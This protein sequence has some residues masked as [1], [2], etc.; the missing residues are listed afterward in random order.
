MLQETPCAVMNAVCSLDWASNIHPPAQS[1]TK[2]FRLHLTY[3]NPKAHSF[4]GHSS[5]SCTQAFVT[6][7]PLAF[8]CSRAGQTERVEWGRREWDELSRAMD[9]V[10]RPSPPPASCS[11][12]PAPVLHCHVPSPLSAVKGKVMAVLGEPPA[13]THLHSQQSRDSSR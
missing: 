4:L 12:P 2:T 7:V 11:P 8:F 6:L 13:G 3:L 5:K 1:A 10:S 9:A